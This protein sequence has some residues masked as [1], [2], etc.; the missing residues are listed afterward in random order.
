MKGHAQNRPHETAQRVTMTLVALAA[1]LLTWESAVRSFAIPDWTLPAPSLIAQTLVSDW[2]ILGPAFLSTLRVTMTSL[3]LAIGGGVTLGILV[4]RS[5]ILDATLSPIAV[6]MQVTPLV[7]IA[8]LLILYIGAHATLYVAAFLVAFFPMLAGTLS[9][10]RT[11]DPALQ[12][13]FTLYDASPSQ[14][15]WRLEF[16]SA[17]PFIMAGLRTAGGLALVGA[18]VAE[19]VSGAIGDQAGL[20]YRI[21]EASYRLNMPR[22]FAALLLIALTGIMIYA[23][24]GLVSRLVLSRWSAPRA[25]MPD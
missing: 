17:L 11:I 12:D 4:S 25:P 22:L 16:P 7:A 2:T 19:F 3:M 23:F 15:L 21:V 18:V 5:R 8:P 14:R 10:L 13:L 9:G 1:L 24:T 6:V 20:A